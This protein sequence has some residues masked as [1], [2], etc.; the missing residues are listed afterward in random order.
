MRAKRTS[1]AESQR[2]ALRVALGLP[3]N[4]PGTVHD[5]DDDP[6]AEADPVEVA[7]QRLD[8]RLQQLTA[9]NAALVDVVQTLI[10]RM[11]I[12]DEAPGPDAD[13]LEAEQAARPRV[14]RVLRAARP[15]ATG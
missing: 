7:L 3:E 5:G 15:R 4:P 10:A 12:E 14:P 1:A 2:V 8:E 6:V 9:T 13:L 11:P